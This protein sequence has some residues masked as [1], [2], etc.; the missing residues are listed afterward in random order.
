MGTRK[1]KLT[2]YAY[3]AK[4]F[5]ENRD[6]TG[7]E[8]ALKDI[9]GQCTIDVA[10]DA[11]QMDKLKRSKSMLKGRPSDEHEGHTVV[12]FRRKWQE[13]YGGGAPK[14][15]KA[16][17]TNWDYDEDGFIGNGSLVEV[18]L[19]VYDTSR[20]NIVG[21]RLEK[22]KVVEHKVYNPDEDVVE[23]DIPETPPPA[24]KAKASK[25][26]MDDEIPF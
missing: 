17:G 6:L 4:V 9:G 20:K 10:L 15:V 25:A 19:N 13:E 1:V 3:W 7:Y 21:T 14:V 16:D 23:D 18:L 26:V 11:E 2:G 8:D 12:R 22:V 5:E 24:P